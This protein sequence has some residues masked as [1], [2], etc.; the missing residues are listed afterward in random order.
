[1]QLLN[2]GTILFIT[3]LVIEKTVF[4]DLSKRPIE[5]LVGNLAGV[6]GGLVQ[7]VLGLLLVAL[8][9]HHGVGGAAAETPVLP[10]LHLVREVAD[11]ARGVLCVGQKGRGGEGVN[12]VVVPQVVQQPL[13]HR[14][15][16]IGHVER[17]VGLA[18]D[19]KVL[20]LVERNCLV[21]AGLLIRRL[22]ALG[23]CAEC[24]EIHL[25]KEK[26]PFL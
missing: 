12:P 9:L 23:I 10:R 8:H 11:L 25:A 2:F 6:F 20:N 26:K 5:D 18:V 13:V 21:L 4:D 24:P 17:V 16:E 7:L 22:V 15:L 14:R 1:M 3:P 19:A